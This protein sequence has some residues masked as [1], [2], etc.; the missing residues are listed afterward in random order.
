MGCKTVTDIKHM[1]LD[2]KVGQL[3][4]Y[5]GHGVFTNE[6]SAFYKDLVHQVRDNHVGGIIW[7]LSDVYEAAFLTQRLQRE[8]KIPLLISA[9]LEALLY[10]SAR[11]MRARHCGRNR[12]LYCTCSARDE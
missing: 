3:F 5:P 6:Q 11:R 7:F 2:E 1:S 10:R 12:T 8:A 4:V 9:D